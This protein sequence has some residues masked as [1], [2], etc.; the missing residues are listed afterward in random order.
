VVG[1]TPLAESAVEKEIYVQPKPLGDQGTLLQALGSILLVVLLSITV[2]GIAS[3]L[4]QKPK[5][6]KRRER[7]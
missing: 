6:A 3:T 1:E 2:P 4:R 5:G 7:A